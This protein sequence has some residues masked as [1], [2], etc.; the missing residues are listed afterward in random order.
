MEPI[1]N[2]EKNIETTISSSVR[3]E[4]VHCNMNNDSCGDLSDIDLKDVPA[5]LEATLKPRPYEA[6]TLF[7]ID[8]D[9]IWG[10]SNQEQE[11]QDYKERAQQEQHKFFEF[12]MQAALDM[13]TRPGDFK[14]NEEQQRYLDQGPNLQNF[15]RGSLVF[16]NT[17]T[18]FQAEHEDI[19]ELQ[20]NLEDQYHFMRNTM[21]NNAAH[22]NLSAQRKK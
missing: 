17:A 13:E 5:Q 18:R 7:N 20:N 16:I 4:N 2:P 12:V 1:I 10:S 9:E 14:P 19:V 15:I 11:V 6:S 21:I 8:L 22:H 3:L